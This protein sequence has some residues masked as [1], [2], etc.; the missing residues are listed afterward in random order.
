MYQAYK[1]DV[2]KRTEFVN[3]IDRKPEPR[4]TVVPSAARQVRPPEPYYWEM[5]TEGRQDFWRSKF[6]LHTA[7]SF[8][9]TLHPTVAIEANLMDP[10]MGGKFN[11]SLIFDQY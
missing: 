2:E 3:S 5:S 4:N 11:I 6:T 10:N 1:R 9:W 8:Y 7:A